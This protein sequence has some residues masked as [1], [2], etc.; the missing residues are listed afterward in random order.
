MGSLRA[1]VPGEC[2]GDGM[3]EVGSSAAPQSRLQPFTTALHEVFAC[4][5][6]KKPMSPRPWG[7]LEPTPALQ[8]RADEVRRNMPVLST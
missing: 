4:G 5:R 6:S 3:E 7:R 1:N 8:D 2:L